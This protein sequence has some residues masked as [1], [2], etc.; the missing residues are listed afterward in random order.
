MGEICYLCSAD[1]SHVSVIYGAG[2]AGY[3]LGLYL[4]S[5]VVVYYIYSTY[6]NYYYIYYIL[7]QDTVI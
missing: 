5:G 2:L 4:Y 7:I 6:S 3:I 1:V